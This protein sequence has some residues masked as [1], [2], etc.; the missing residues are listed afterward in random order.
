MNVKQQA[1][2]YDTFGVWPTGSGNAMIP[3]GWVES[4]PE[5]GALSQIPFFNVRNRTAGLM[6]NNQHKRDSMD[7]GFIIESLGLDFHAMPFTSSINDWTTNYE[8]IVD[9]YMSHVF[10]V[11]LPRHIGVRVKVQQDVVLKTHAFFCAPG[12]GLTGGGYARGQASDFSALTNDNGW[13]HHCSVNSQG[14]PSLDNRWAFPEPL[15]I[16]RNASFSVELELNEYVRGLLIAMEDDEGTFFGDID[17]DDDIR[18]LRPFSTIQCSIFGSE[19]VQ[20]RG[21]YHR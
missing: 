18:E 1:L 10:M 14:V 7:A 21:Q 19:L 16:P 5:M 8:L 13:D 17:G 11:D 4:Y 20:Q 15:E 3:D 12:Y 2:M 6:W 9:D